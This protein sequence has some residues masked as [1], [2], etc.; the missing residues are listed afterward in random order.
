MVVLQGN[1]QVSADIGERGRANVPH[2]PGKPNRALELDFR[3]CQAAGAAT[4]EEYRA[5]KGC[6]MGGDKADPFQQF[7]RFGP[8]LPEGGLIRHLR[9]GDA[10][11]V[12]EHE[13]STWRP[14]QEVGL[15]GDLETLD[16]DHGKRA[17]AVAAVV[18]GLKVDRRKPVTA[19]RCAAP[20]MLLESSSRSHAESVLLQTLARCAPPTCSVGRHGSA[21]AAQA[22]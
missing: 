3:R 22:P 16:D 1:P 9:P 20:Q 7:Q 17:G 2:L 8:N 12:A 15:A 21:N 6:L 19:P 14:D 10:V 11:H 5:V 4:F 18:R 13:L